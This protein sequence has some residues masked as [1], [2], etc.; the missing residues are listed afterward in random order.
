MKPGADT[1][2]RGKQL[3]LGLP[4]TASASLTFMLFGAPAAA[5]GRPD[6]LRTAG[7]LS[8][9][10]EPGRTEF[11]AP[12]S[13]PP[14]EPRALLPNQASALR[15]SQRQRRWWSPAAH[16]AV[17]DGGVRSSPSPTFAARC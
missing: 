2:G 5:L 11:R 8:S 6:P 14:R 1:P 17:V 4:G 15:C 16:S 12:Y 9:T 7:V 13:I 3:V 10:S